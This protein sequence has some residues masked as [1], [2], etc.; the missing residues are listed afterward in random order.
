MYIHIY[1]HTNMYVYIH[2]YIHTYIQ[3]YIYLHIHIYIYI[4]MYMYIYIYI[5]ILYIYIYHDQFGKRETQGECYHEVRG[6]RCTPETARPSPPGP[7]EHRQLAVRGP[8]GSAHRARD[9]DR[10]PICIY[11]EIHTHTN[12]YACSRLAITSGRCVC[13]CVH[14]YVDVCI[15]VCICVQKHAHIIQRRTAIAQ[16]RI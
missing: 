3:T 10:S 13:I 15:C 2:T 11:V 16:H 8:Q 4:C 9:S 14:M 6:K 12:I 5:H 7:G 1:I